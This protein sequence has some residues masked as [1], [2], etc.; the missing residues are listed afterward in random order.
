VTVST[1]PDRQLRPDYRG[2]VLILAL[3]TS[4]PAVTV[5]VC[6]VGA[7]PVATPGT[8]AIAEPVTVVAAQREVAANRHG[9]LLAAMVGKV[10]ADAGVEPSGL[11]A[12]AVGLGPGPFTG[13]RVGVVTAKAMGDALGIPVYGEC[14]LRLF[15]AQPD[16]PEL[17]RI[18]VATDARRKQLY[19][20]VDDRCRCVAGPEVG[21]AE[22]A[23]EAFAAA[24]VQ[25]VAGEG[26]QLYPEQF[27][28]FEVLADVYPSALTLAELVAA[29][30]H[31]GA[32]SE[33]VAPMYLRRPDAVPPGRPKR[34]TPA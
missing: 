6:A 3:D 12:V 11:A 31:T 23:A 2:E 32:P 22:Q 26:P 14:S 29:R 19:W 28:D 1:V 30:V 7:E 4:T 25:Q 8:T 9:E 13:L 5:A 15:A 27:A 16:R 34:V 10:L 24:G 18:G 17:D 20:A 21:T 33:D